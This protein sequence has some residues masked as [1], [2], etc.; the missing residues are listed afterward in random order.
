MPIDLDEYREQSRE[1]WA[2]MASG[3]EKRREWVM[4]Q[5]GL[6]RLAGPRARAVLALPEDEHE[7]SRDAIL[8]NMEQFRNEDGS[9]A[10]PAATW[11]VLV[12]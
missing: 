5:T 3:W 4:E 7:A 12:R 11:G 8:R 9:Y 2:R 10:V 1:S 6:V